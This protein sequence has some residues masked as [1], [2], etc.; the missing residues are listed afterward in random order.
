MEYGISHSFEDETL[1]AKARWF[2]E[3]PI[4]ERLREAFEGMILWQKLCKWEPPDDRKTFKTFRVLE[5]P[6][7]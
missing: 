4:E 3:K 6:R 7:R 5:L 1:E 2:M